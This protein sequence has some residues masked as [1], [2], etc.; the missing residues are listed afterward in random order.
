[1]ESMFLTA[2]M[3]ENGCEEVH[4]QFLDA[5]K[6]FE[7]A[8]PQ[9]VLPRLTK[10]SLCGFNMGLPWLKI[11]RKLVDFGKLSSLYVSKCQSAAHFFAE[12]GSDAAITRFHLKHLAVDCLTLDSDYEIENHTETA[13]LDSCLQG[14]FLKCGKLESLHVGWH[15]HWTE[16]PRAEFLIRTISD[17]LSRDGESLRIL[18]VHPHNGES[19][20]DSLGEDLA[21]ACRACPNLQQLGYQLGY[22]VLDDCLNTEEADEALDEF[23][24]G[25][26]QAPSWDNRS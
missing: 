13:L 1:M 4:H 16:E 6:G 21:R 9:N 22:G 5:T 14:V 24:V 19:E 17:K 26:L 10:L 20:V 11:L 15:E 25:S 12:L 3:C 7:S 2:D 23:V 8:S 18:A